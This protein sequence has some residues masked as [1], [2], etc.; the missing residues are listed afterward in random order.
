MLPYKVPTPGVFWDLH[1]PAIQLLL[2]RGQPCFKERSLARTQI[3]RRDKV[4]GGR[5][6]AHLDSWPRGQTNVSF[7][8]LVFP[9]VSEKKHRRLPR[10]ENVPSITQSQISMNCEPDVLCQESGRYPRIFLPCLGD[11]LRTELLGLRTMQ[12]SC[13][14]SNRVFINLTTSRC[15]FYGTLTLEKAIFKSPRTKKFKSSA[16]NSKETIFLNEAHQRRG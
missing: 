7:G 1:L 8:N 16:S 15:R 9:Q 2:R 12:V 3:G 14:L 10:K 11:W 13:R 4:P 6:Q 5:P